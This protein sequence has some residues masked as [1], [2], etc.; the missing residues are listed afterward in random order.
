[1]KKE[2][3]KILFFLIIISEI[4]FLHSQSAGD[5]DTS[6]GVDGFV[7]T[8]FE[9]S[10]DWGKKVIID[11][12]EKIIVGG[13][14]IIDST[15]DFVLAR[16]LSDGSLDMEFG[17]EGKINTDFNNNYDSFSML[18][19]D[20]NNKIISVGGSN[21]DFAL[22]RHNMDGS[23]DIFFGEDGKV[24][25]DFDNEWDCANYVVLDSEQRIIVC[26][27]SNHDFCIARYHIDGSLD[28]TFGIN[29][30]V[31]TDINESF[32]CGNSIAINDC[33]QIY[34]CGSTSREDSI[35]FALV[36]YNNDGSLDTDFGNNGKIITDFYGRNDVAKAIKIDMDGNIIVAGSSKISDNNDFALA[37]YNPY[38]M[39]VT[40]FGDN[41]K[42]LTDFNDTWDYA[43][44]IVI[45][46]ENRIIVAGKADTMYA[47]ARYHNNGDL[48]ESFGI[49][50][51]VTTA[52]INTD[53]G[54]EGWTGIALDSEENIVV[55]GYYTESAIDVTVDFII[56][57]YFSDN[58]SIYNPITN[59]SNKIILNQN[60]PNPFNPSTTIEF[61][62][63]NQSDIELTIY[64]I[65]GQKIKTLAQNE[66]A[67]GR[68]SIIWNGDDEFNN[69]VISGIYFYKLEVNGKPEQIRKCILIR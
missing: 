8:D 18:V 52:Y 17:I 46:N 65:K 41:G 25:T 53:R 37:K 14:A 24:T 12:N 15:V 11:S 43:S 10:F 32:D 31:T 23:L 33:N 9:D 55:A 26:G 42:V 30:K 7:I 40:D 50:G 62:I 54:S 56:A 51:K 34:M 48:D 38:G 59:I 45:D 3:I 1:M 69:P 35:N 58:V 57:R 5:I 20:V 29:G 6:F 47:I 16:Y 49:N 66:F 68:H 28:S 61:S 19:S 63:K 67:K 2:V 36:K 4:S 27:N 22:T 13:C 44:E 39:L 21:G 60:Y 64:N